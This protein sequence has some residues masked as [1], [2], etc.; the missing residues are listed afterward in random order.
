[1]TPEQLEH[2]DEAQRR[3]ATALEFAAGIL[4]TRPALLGGPAGRLEA[5]TDDVVRLARF[6]LTGL[7]CDEPRE[8]VVYVSDSVDG[9]VDL[10]KLVRDD[11]P[12]PEVTRDDV[13][14]WSDLVRSEVRTWAASVHAVAGEDWPGIRIP[15]LPPVFAARA[16]CAEVDGQAPAVPG[17]RNVPGTAQAG[18]IVK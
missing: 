15:D 3:R 5:T 9:L 6:I 1:M 7:D 18:R 13:A 2:L 4:R 10:L 12:G 17:V 16:A 14:S 11:Y 8:P